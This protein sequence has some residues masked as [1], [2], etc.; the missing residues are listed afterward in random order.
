VHARPQSLPREGKRLTE[1]GRISVNLNTEHLVRCIE[2]LDGSLDRLHR[3]ETGTLDYEIFRNAVIKGFEL[4]LETTGKLLRRALKAYTGRP[5]EIDQLTFREI[6]RHAAKHELLS[7]E[8]VERWFT[9]REN[10]NTTAHDYG[11]AFAEETL[12]LLPEFLLDARALE[13]VLRARLGHAG[14]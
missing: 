4:T 12:V 10:R 13:A 6:L 3:A 11:E 14:P 5:R 7:P 8:A 1:E 9:Y 2:T